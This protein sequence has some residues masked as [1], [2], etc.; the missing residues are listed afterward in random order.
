MGTPIMEQVQ[1]ASAS[2]P[3]IAP[4]EAAALLDRADT[5][6]VD[7]R[8]DSE[9]AKSGKV[10]GAVHASRGLIEFKA[11]PSSPLHDPVFDPNKTIVLYCAS[12]GRSALAGKALMDLGYRDVRN[13]GGFQAW[14]QAGQPVDLP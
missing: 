14:V 3:G 8:E 4:T 5:V 12:G 2:V 7:V 10:K 9:L 6:F 13:L 1:A 11:D